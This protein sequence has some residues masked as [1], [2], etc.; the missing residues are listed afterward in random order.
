MSTFHDISVLEGK[1]ILCGR[2][3]QIRDLVT[4]LSIILLSFVYQPVRAQLQ[5]VQSSEIRSFDGHE[6]HIVSL[7]YAA[8]LTENFRMT[9]DSTMKGVLGE[10]FG[11]DALVGALNQ[12]NCTGLRIYYGKKDDGTPA[13]VLVGVDKSGNDLTA[14]LVLEDG[15]ICPP[16][17]GVEN[18]LKG[19]EKVATLSELNSLLVRKVDKK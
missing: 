18:S 9:A 11:K 14:G 3:N 8:S 16:W 5:S 6:N 15:Y 10:F 12:K 2:F 4:F 19:I 1:N 7:D 13:L 17:C